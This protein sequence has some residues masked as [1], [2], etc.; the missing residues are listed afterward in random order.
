MLDLVDLTKIYPGQS[1]PVVALDKVSLTVQRGEIFG[2]IGRSGAGKST[3]IRCINLLERPTSGTVRVDGL[4]LSALGDHE[5]NQ[6][7]RDIGMVFRHFN[8]L[9]SR[10]ASDNIALPLEIAGCKPPE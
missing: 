10:T 4:D 9:S 1:A 5:L 7:R 8:L 3:L 2:I 6:A